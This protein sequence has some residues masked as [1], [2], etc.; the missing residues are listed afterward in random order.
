MSKKQVTATK[1]KSF[2]IFTTPEQVREYKR[3]EVKNREIIKLNEELTAENARLLT[4]LDEIK[5]KWW[6][7]LM[8]WGWN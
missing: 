1:G 2:N 6:Y 8:T 3:I 5:L 7:K 4:D